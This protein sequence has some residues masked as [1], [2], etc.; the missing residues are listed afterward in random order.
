MRGRIAKAVAAFVCPYS[1]IPEASRA[2]IF[3]SFRQTEASRALI[4]VSFRQM[5]ASRALDI[6]IR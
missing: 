6:C 1:H 2:L 5:E 4:F 3:V